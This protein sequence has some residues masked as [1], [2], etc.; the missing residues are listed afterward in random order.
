MPLQTQF[1]LIFCKI[2]EIMD[3]GKNALYDFP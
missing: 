2:L 3:M 1:C